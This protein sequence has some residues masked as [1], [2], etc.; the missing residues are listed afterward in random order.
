MKKFRSK[1]VLIIS[2]AVIAVLL[3]GGIVFAFVGTDMFKSNKDMF[4]KYASQIFSEN[5][6][7]IDNKIVEYNNKKANSS[8]E[9]IGKINAEV[10]SET[11]NKDTLNSIKNMNINVAGNVDKLNNKAE[12]LAKV[13]YSDKSNFTVSY[14]NANDVTG[15]KFNDLASKYFAV[16]KND[17]SSVIKKLGVNFANIDAP[18][19]N[20]SNEEKELLKQKYSPIIKNCLE[21]CTFLKVKGINSEGYTIEIS[22][23]KMLEV[24]TKVLEELQK[25]EQ[26]IEIVNKALGT[27]FK[28]TEIS[29]MASVLKGYKA[30]NGK[31]SFTVYQKDG[32]VNKIAI[33]FNDMVNLTLAK[34]ST[35][36][37]VNYNLVV[38]T[39]N[40]SIGIIAEYS[41]LG[42]IQNVKEN[43]ELDIIAGDSYK[44]IFENTVNFTNDIK[45]S[46]F[47]NNEYNDLNK[48]KDGQVGKFF[49][50]LFSKMDSVN[51]EKIKAAGITDVNLWTYIFPSA[52][53]LTINNKQ[54]FYQNN[55]VNELNNDIVEN[56][57]E[58]KDK[59]IKENNEIDSLLDSLENKDNTK[60]TDNKTDTN[61]TNNTNNE[62]KTSTNIVTNIEKIEKE[63]FNAMFNQYE[64]QNVRGATVK[65]LVMKVIASNMSDEER[66]VKLTGD[67]VLTGDQVPDTI[68][69]NKTYD[70]K[71]S[72]DIEGYINSIE[73]KANN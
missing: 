71:C 60:T 58:N 49:E 15:V 32:K 62:N 36:N 19:I 2:I 3:I 72:T 30:S 59:T 47:Q 48:L 27:N 21:D 43:Y 50:T 67:V 4:F 31:T 10:D 53:K 13:N 18:K 29:V 52:D 73:I 6:G 66:Q 61:N 5:N 20:I 9:F 56:K 57:E 46:D 24:A 7:L 37:N 39:Q 42:S 68:D 55:S 14:K 12:A 16:N 35:D 26:S 28:N 23:Q 45:I 38:E 64:G 17:L 70:V 1:K 63:T 44:Y 25:D 33:Q 54:L 40:Y 65:S 22:N 69:V 41:G 34:T 51:K 8:Y 11:I